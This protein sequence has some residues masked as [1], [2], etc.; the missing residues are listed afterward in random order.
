MTNPRG[1]GQQV[2]FTHIPL[3]DW[4]QD[5]ACYGLAPQFDDRLGTE[6]VTAQTIRQRAAKRVCRTKCDVL[7]ECEAAI[8]PLRDEGVRAG[9]VLPPLGG[10]RMTARDKEMRRLLVDGWSL[11]AAA[12]AASRFGRK[13]S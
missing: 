9:H 4:R 12:A 7:A 1:M 6:S 2:E 5:A 3:E 11:D 13:A 10:S 8:D